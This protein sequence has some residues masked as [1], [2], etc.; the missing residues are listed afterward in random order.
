M[1]V[2]PLQTALTV[3]VTALVVFFSG[4]RT[5]QA[6]P[7]FSRKYQTSCL[8]C[9]TVFPTLNPFGE[10]FRRNGY[11]MPSQD[12]SADSD[13]IKAAI[14]PMGQQEYARMFPKAVYPAQIMDSVPLS[15][16]V[17]GGVAVN[18]PGSDAHDSAGNAFTWDGIARELHL[19]GAGS[20]NDSLTYFSQ[21][22][23]SGNGFDLETGYL[24]WNDV[25]GP[26][27]YLNIWVGRLM[28]PSLTSWGVHSSYLADTNL[29]AVS[30]GGLYNPALTFALGPTSHT[31]GIEANGVIAH[32]LGYAAGW[33]SSGV[34]G[35]GLKTPSAQDVY[36]HIGAKIGGLSLDGEG[37]SAPADAMRPWAETSLTL[38]AFAYRGLT[39]FD[40]GTGAN[41]NNPALPIGQRDVMTAIGG[42]VRLMLGSVQLTSG[43]Q[44]EYHAGPYPGLPGTAPD[45]TTTPPTPGANGAADT[46][47]AR[48]IVQYNELSYVVYPWLVPAVRTEFTT[49]NLTSP[50]LGALTATS[51]NLLRVVAGAAM[52]VRANVKV[53]IAATA[54]RVRG[55]PPVGDWSTAGGSRIGVP[56][57]TG[58][59]QVEQINATVAW[60]F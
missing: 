15:A 16:M 14:I 55:A 28:A 29:P 20:F 11:R 7:S 3:V 17:N 13:A 44:T 56:G 53:V 42:Q 12:G 19:F 50:N 1:R 27:H 21:A 24:L 57:K 35:A 41:A 30:I 22:T 38:D 47:S 23:F 59:L 8:T 34:A 5:A 54:E 52:L 25:V 9:H 36:A 58:T 45:A 51:A 40:N 60:A 6:V 48:S 46:S 4:M 37:G 2:S 32:R 31:D 10:A 43:A 39:L 18:L 33:I 49:L 26:N